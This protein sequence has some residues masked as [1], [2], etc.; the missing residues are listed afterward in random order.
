MSDV[1]ITAGPF[2][3]TARFEAA[4]PLTSAGESSPLT[5]REV[6]SRHMERAS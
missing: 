1:V 6:L 2:T 4:A 3:L 5:L